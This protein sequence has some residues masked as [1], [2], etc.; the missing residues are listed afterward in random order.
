MTSWEHEFAPCFVGVRVDQSSIVCEV[1]CRSLSVFLL[2]FWSLFVFGLLFL[3]ILLASFNLIMWFLNIFVFD[4]GILYAIYSKELSCKCKRSFC[5]GIIRGVRPFVFVYCYV[6]TLGC[7]HRVLVVMLY[8]IWQLFL[9]YLF[10]WPCVL[11]TI[12]MTVK[13]TDSIP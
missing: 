13:V 7:F 1:F 5:V 4:L 12:K 6:C 11:S 3:V 8:N 9:Y 2:T 10:R